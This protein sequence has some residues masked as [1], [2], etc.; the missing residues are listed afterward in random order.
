M[1]KDIKKRAALLRRVVDIYSGGCGRDMSGE[2]ALIGMFEASIII[3]ALQDIFAR[4]IPEAT[5][6]W[7]PHMI[8][9]FETPT[10][11]TDILYTRGI[12]A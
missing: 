3:P 11:A 5:Y 7:Q 1:K 6:L 12:R 4:Q 9:Q 2:G 8:D 10:K